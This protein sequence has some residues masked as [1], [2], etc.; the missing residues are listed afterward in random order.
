MKNSIKQN[1]DRLQKALE[2]I[3]WVTSA[4][5]ETRDP[6][7]AG[8][9]QRV[10]NLSL[11]LANDMRLAEEQKQEIRMAA[12]THDLGKICIPSEILCKPTRLNSIEFS[13]I[14]MHPQAGHDL[15]ENVDLPWSI[16]N[17][18]LQH[19]ERLNG[20][21]YPRGLKGKDILLAARII[22][23]AD[24]VEAMS[25]HRPYRPALGIEKALNEVSSKKGV[26]YDPDVVDS[27]SNLFRERGLPISQL[28]PDVIE[29]IAR[30]IHADYL[31]SQRESVNSEDPS[32]AQWNKLPNYLKESN[33]QQAE[34]I[35]KK[36]NRI[37]CTVHKVTDLD[38]QRM[39]FIE[40]EVEIMAEM[41]HQRWNSER[42]FNGWE[43]SERRDVIAR[44]SPY[45]VP[46]IELTDDVKEQDRQMVRNIPELLAK[47]RLEIHR[48]SGGR[49][50]MTKG[51]TNE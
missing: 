9:Q 33:R 14:K 38:I 23:V 30:A 16:A 5:V 31:R 49:G 44:T 3:V 42:L 10:T 32:L 28:V 13:M 4:A 29:T 40:D 37:G 12:M 24:V 7:T 36:L 26:F 46:W 27:F 1:S 35:M 43:L 50:E 6:Y 17:I 11:A 8:H 2:S 19:H 39:V 18:T 51:I 20:S 34:H 41:E 45:L 22:A 15:F 21:G 48:Q 47:V 25:S